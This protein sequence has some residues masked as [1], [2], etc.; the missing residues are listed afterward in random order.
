MTDL[1]NRF[2]GEIL[3]FKTVSNVEPHPGVNKEPGEDLC[4]LEDFE[5]IGAVI[6]R[7]MR[8][9]ID[10]SN[11]YVYDHV[12]EEDLA[13]ERIYDVF[14]NEDI[15]DRQIDLEDY[16]GQIDGGN[17]NGVSVSAG[18]IERGATEERVKQSDEGAS[19]E[20]DTEA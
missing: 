7:F 16:V 1:K 5:P 20:V 6:A 4:R 3:P 14:D 17:A 10:N 8:S 11:E 13:Q 9:G 12:N 15:L 19:S 2:T 18:E